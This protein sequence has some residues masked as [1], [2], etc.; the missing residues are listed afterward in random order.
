MPDRLEAKRTRNKVALLIWS[1]QALRTP[2]KHLNNFSKQAACLDHRVRCLLNRCRRVASLND[3]NTFLQVEIADRV[4]PRFLS[5]DTWNCVGT[6]VQIMFTLLVQRQQVTPTKKS[7][8]TLRAD[9]RC[10]P[11]PPLMEFH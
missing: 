5:I 6:Q 4:F 2:R 10:S 7:E 11:A 3:Q 9:S 1:P 8:R